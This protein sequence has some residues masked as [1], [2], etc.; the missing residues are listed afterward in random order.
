[1]LNM[2]NMVIRNEKVLGITVVRK[3]S[4]DWLVIV[5]VF[6]TTYL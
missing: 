6:T 2:L 1:M 3:Y 5:L 4:K